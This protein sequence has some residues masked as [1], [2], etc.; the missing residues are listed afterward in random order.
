MSHAEGG[1]HVNGDG[2]IKGMCRMLDIWRQC[3][4]RWEV[5]KYVRNTK[6]CIPWGLVH[7]KCNDEHT[8]AVCERILP[9]ALVN[10]FKKWQNSHNKATTKQRAATLKQKT[11][12]VAA[13]GRWQPG[14]RVWLTG[15]RKAK[16]N[17]EEGI[18]QGDGN[19]PLER[20]AP[21]C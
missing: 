16:L 19:A 21:T 2:A 18:I 11:E 5:G 8:R 14:T 7:K 20:P 17:G 9:Q 4:D 6:Q 1:L 15:L 3:E 13:Q 12:Q 10:R